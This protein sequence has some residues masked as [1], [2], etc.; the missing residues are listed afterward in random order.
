LGQGLGRF[1]FSRA[2]PS[3]TARRRVVDVSPAAA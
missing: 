1:G 3:F 2:K